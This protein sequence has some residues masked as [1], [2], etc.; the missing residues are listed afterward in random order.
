MCL[1]FFPAVE[2]NPYFSFSKKE[3][4]SQVIGVIDGG[5]MV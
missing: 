3:D 4:K 5:G 1:G 2:V